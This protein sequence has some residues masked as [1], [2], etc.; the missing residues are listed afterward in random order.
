MRSSSASR[1]TTP[2]RSSACRS[3]R[4]ARCSS[5]PAWVRAPEIAGTLY[6]H[7]DAS[8]RS[9]EDALPARTIATSAR[10]RISSSKT[11]R[12]RARSSALGM[13]AAR[14]Q[15]Q[16]DRRGARSDCSPLREGAPSGLLSEAGCPAIADPGRRAG[17]GRAPRRLP[18]RAARRPSS[19][20]LALMARASRAS[21]SPSAATCPREPTIA[22]RRSARSSGSRRSATA[23]LHRDALSQR[24]AA[25]RA[26]R[27]CARGTRLC[28]A[29]DL[30]LP[31][32][33]IAHGNDRRMAQG[34]GR[35]RPAPGRVSAASGL[36][37]AAA[38]RRWRDRR[39]PAP[40]RSANFSARFPR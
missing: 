30:T 31:A 17:R 8:R 13:P 4:S 21:A 33:T 35:D 19:I 5:A 3:S 15:H 37:R 22:S 18:R 16:G 36:R 12:A 34:Q 25:R 10:V 24:R 14:A 26:P 1:P 7:S 9:A 27:T 11:P 38:R 40:K 23:D 20:V 28:V 29:A 2:P 32:E 39:P 6:L